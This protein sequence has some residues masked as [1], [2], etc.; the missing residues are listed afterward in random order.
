MR[1][2]FLI[3]L[4]FFISGCAGKIYPSPYA[5]RGNQIRYKY[6]FNGV[7]CDYC[8]KGTYIYKLVNL[9]KIMCN[10]CYS[11]QKDKYFK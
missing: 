5:D 3:I 1:Y 6:Y 9:K 11:K 2:I 8:S 7:K 10:E 4:L